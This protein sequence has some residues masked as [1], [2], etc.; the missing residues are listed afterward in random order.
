MHQIALNIGDPADYD[1]NSDI[2]GTMYYLYD[3]YFLAKDGVISW[4]SFDFAF[5]KY[6]DNGTPVDEKLIW[7]KNEYKKPSLF[8]KIK[9]IFKR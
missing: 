6:L 4:G 7:K 9:N 3:F 8:E 1:F 5:V 2:W